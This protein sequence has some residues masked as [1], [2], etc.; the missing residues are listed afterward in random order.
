MLDRRLNQLQRANQYFKVPLSI[1]A[2]HWKCISTDDR[3]W[4]LKPYL[5][6]SYKY[7]RKIRKKKNIHALKIYNRT[8]TLFTFS[9]SIPFKKSIYDF[10]NVSLFGSRN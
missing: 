5:G 7:N 6:E 4:P 8:R 9:A 10:L 3:R 2:D 1:C